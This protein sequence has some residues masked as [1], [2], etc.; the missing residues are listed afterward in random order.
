M[1]SFTAGLCGETNRSI[2]AAT[3]KEQIT[4]L[5]TVKW[6]VCGERN[7]TGFLTAANTI[8]ALSIDI[9]IDT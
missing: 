6:G 4:E 5:S 2:L 1:D 9:D 8:T 7:Q 3:V